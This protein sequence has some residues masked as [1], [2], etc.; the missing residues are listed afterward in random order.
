MS[1][2]KK[3]S[4]EEIAKELLITYLEEYKIDEFKNPIKA[5]AII[6][7]MYRIILNRISQEEVREVPE[8]NVGNED[9]EGAVKFY[10][11]LLNYNI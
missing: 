1:D 3:I 2:N 5:A 9:Q 11:F 7:D 6:S 4:F 8:L 10:R